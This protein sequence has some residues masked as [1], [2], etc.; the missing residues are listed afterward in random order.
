MF[1]LLLQ[2]VRLMPRVLLD[3]DAVSAKIIQVQNRS[4]A[5][6]GIPDIGKRLLPT[7]GIE[8]AV[9]D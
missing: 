4:V 2:P 3:Q 5:V 7:G 1:R 6:E 9:V 8:H